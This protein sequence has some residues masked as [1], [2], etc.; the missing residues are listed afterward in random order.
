[1]VIYSKG[2]ETRKLLRKH[3]YA[4]V[5]LS[6]PLKYSKNGGNLGQVLTNITLAC[7]LIFLLIVEKYTILCLFNF[8]LYKFSNLYMKF[9]KIIRRRDR[10]MAQLYE[11]GDVHVMS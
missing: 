6:L 1:M 10:D 11:H 8:L 4:K 3:L 2:N 9:D 7:F 5:T